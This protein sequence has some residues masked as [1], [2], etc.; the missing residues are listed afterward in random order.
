M[1][2]HAKCE[3]QVTTRNREMGLLV[4]LMQVVYMSDQWSLIT[5]TVTDIEP[6]YHISIQSCFYDDRLCVRLFSIYRFRGNVSWK[7]L[8]KVI[9]GETSTWVWEYTK[10]SVF[11]TR[12]VL[13]DQL[14]VLCQDCSGGSGMFYVKTVMVWFKLK[15]RN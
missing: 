9:V 2:S 5:N 3:K 1:T 6:W 13:A 10:A 7:T 8:K 4:A 14:C 12:T 11:Y 15:S